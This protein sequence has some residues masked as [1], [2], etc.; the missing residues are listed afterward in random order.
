MRHG[1]GFDLLCGSCLRKERRAFPC[2]SSPASPAPTRAERSPLPQSGG[3]TRCSAVAT[4]ASCCMNGMKRAACSNATAIWWT[5]ATCSSR[6][7]AK[8]AK[9]AGRI[10]RCGMPN[11]KRNP[12]FIC[13]REGSYEKDKK[14]A[15]AQLVFRYPRGGAVRCGHSL[16]VI[17]ASRAGES[18]LWWIMAAP[19][20][21]FVVF[22]FY[23]SALIWIFYGSLRGRYRIVCAVE[24]ERLYSVQEIAQQLGIREKEVRSSSRSV[25]PKGTLRAI[26]GRGTGSC[27]TRRSLSPNARS[28][29]SA[30]TAA[31][32]SS[33][34]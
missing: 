5:A 18:A 2:G 24:N 11:G 33:I 19:G 26:S 16:I 9:R 34:N 4:S 28:K 17:G 15:A 27:R 25:F 30:P 7:C 6:T 32:R 23:G 20:I 1:L 12:Y 10:I 13:K 29:A 14:S 3:T 8:G 31:A 22:G 21:A